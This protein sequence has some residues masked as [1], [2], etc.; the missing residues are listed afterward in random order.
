MLEDYATLE[1]CLGELSEILGPI[2]EIEEMEEAPEI[3]VEPIKNSFFTKCE[4]LSDYFGENTA[5][6]FQLCSFTDDESSSSFPLNTS[7]LSQWKCIEKQNQEL[8]ENIRNAKISKKA[9]D[10]ENEEEEK[11]EI[12]QNEEEEEMGEFNEE[13]END[14]EEEE[15]DEDKMDAR[16]KKLV[17]DLF[18]YHPSADERV[19]EEEEEEMGEMTEEQIRKEKEMFFG[20]PDK[21]DK[22]EDP[23]EEE[24]K[25]KINEIE[26]KL[27]APKPWHL[28]GEVN[29]TDRPADSLSALDLDFDFTHVLPP[30]PPTTA[31]LE[32]IITDRI[33]SMNFDDVVRPKSIPK[34]ADMFT[35]SSE[36]PR[37]GLADEYAEDYNKMLNGDD[38]ETLTQQQQEVIDMWNTVESEFNRFTEPRTIAKKP[39]DKIDIKHG[40]SLDV[41]EKPTPTPIP[42]AVMAPVGSEKKLKSDVEKTH[43]MKV[44]ERRE[45]KKHAKKNQVVKDAMKGIL[46]S[47]SG[48][49]GAEVQI[50]K[51]LKQLE[52]GKLRQIEVIQPGAALTN[53]KPK[54]KSSDAKKYKL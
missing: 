53:E 46:Y 12:I 14:N 11:E 47:Q 35:I 24:T 39:R 34:A 33:T 44:A 31:E 13:E 6:F 21:K 1:S 29:A 10:A 30:A 3:D 18:N 51:N 2:D 54:P 41:E 27:I 43:D 16:D 15:I 4:E 38:K 37:K 40:V 8:L 5:K 17:T 28:S 23:A 22:K 26:E 49:D 7:N 25:E 48:K 19:E 20:K 50:Q 45:W 32:K 9:V 42:E 52:A 36:K